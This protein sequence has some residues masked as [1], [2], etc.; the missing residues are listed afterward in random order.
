MK[1]LVVSDVKQPS[2]RLASWRP[3]DPPGRNR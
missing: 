2:F 1:K 3:P